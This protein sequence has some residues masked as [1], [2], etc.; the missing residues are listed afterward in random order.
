MA[1]Y[2]IAGP[3]GRKVTVR[4]P[5]GASA[6]Q[7]QAKIQQVKSN[8]NQ[9]APP[10]Q[11]REQEIMSNLESPGVAQRMLRGFPGL[12]GALDEIGA[13]ADAVINTVSGGRFGTPYD[14]SLAKRRAA[15]E[16]SDAENPVLN[17][18]LAVGGG[19]A[20]G[21]QLPM[22][23]VFT[24]PVAPTV[25]T[26]GADAMLN[27]GIYGGL[28]GFTEGEGGFLN[29]A[30]QGINTAGTSAAIA[31]PLASAGQA[32]S[33][34]LAATP[35]GS[36]TQQADNIGVTLPT[37]MDGG[38]AS[39]N[40]AGKLGAIPFVGD[41][42]NN[43][44]A[45]AR[46]QTGTAARNISDAVAGGRTSPQQAGEAISNATTQAAGPGAR[47]A[48]NRVYEA[49]ER[50]MQG[51]VAPL[52]ATQR[53]AAELTR[54]QQA[55]TR[56]IHGVALREVEEALGTPNGLSFE[57]ISRLRTR[58]GSMI[59]NN[60][61]PENATARAGLA[62][63]YAALTDDMQTA[64]NTR[65]GAAARQTWERANAVARQAAE[66]RDTVARLVGAEGDKAGEGITDRLVAMASSKSSA[67][68]SRLGQ[69]RRAAGADSWRQLSGA[70]IERLGRNTSDEFS[71]DIFLKNYSQLSDRGR[72]LLF[73]STGDHILPH[74]ENLAAVS[75]RLQQF[76]RL[77]NPSGS[78]GVGAL[79]TA[80]VG[81][82]AGD[83]GATAGTM[84]A[85][86]GLGYL[87]SRPSVVRQAS[88]HAVAMERVLR[89]RAGRGALAGSSAALARVVAEETGEDPEEIQSRIDAASMMPA[90]GRDRIVQSL[91]GAD[92]QETTSEDRSTKFER[93]ARALAQ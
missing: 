81:L 42:I 57:G 64:I 48:T 71:P 55:A 72:Q 59:D 60:I 28:T 25:M 54:Q 50:Q 85:G 68:A 52:S 3:D 32:I 77:G 14:E 24:N 82:G 7:V 70:A 27:A 45:V 67:D 10:K 34:R 89:T 88:R 2:T 51:V 78:G 11:T 74:L 41:D 37:F 36:I 62:S 1:N 92:D 9:F 76:N 33:N 61:D 53:A 65:G 87:M 73:N 83:A 44:V 35:P 30:Q 63:I 12:G 16:R 46:S 80:L 91:M 39:Q 4:A 20:L 13:G 23:R 58:I 26:R 90:S 15:I 49:V 6:E 8:W 69:V 38:R 66:R 86:R 5:D 22:A 29:R 93:L 75:A 17:T 79:L 56:P 43:A 84:I 18:A 31:G 21:S 40:V 19:L 47:A